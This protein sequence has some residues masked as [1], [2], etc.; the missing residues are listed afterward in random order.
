[1][2]LVVIDA[3][4]KCMDGLSETIVS[5]NCGDFTSAEFKKCL[6]GNGIKHTK[7]S[8]YHPASN[9][10]A[11]RAGRAFKEGVEKTEAGY[12]RNCHD[13]CSSIVPTHTQQQKF[14]QPSFS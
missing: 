12:K 5:D 10:N 4:S 7:V 6:A 3:H 9:G 8:P 2:Y 11:K 13:F 1:M 14:L